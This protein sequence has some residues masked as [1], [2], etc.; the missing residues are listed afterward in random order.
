VRPAYYDSLDANSSHVRNAELKMGEL[1]LGAYRSELYMQS[2]ELFSVRSVQ[3]KSTGLPG[4]NSKAW[5]IRLAVEQ[6]SSQCIDC[7]I[8]TIDLAYGLSKTLGNSFLIGSTLGASAHD[9]RLGIGNFSARWSVFANAELT[10]RLNMRL[11]FDKRL[12]AD[13][14]SRHRTDYKTEARYRTSQNTAV[15]AYYSKEI[16]EEFGFSFDYYF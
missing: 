13:G 2:L 16:S 12:Y 14:S 11:D 1:T 6:F 4:D 9:N 7:L 10:Q 5:S 3:A 15:R 8:S